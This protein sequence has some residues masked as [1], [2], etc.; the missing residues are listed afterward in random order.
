MGGR[1]PDNGMV[2]PLC[3]LLLPVNITVGCPRFASKHHHLVE[4]FSLNFIPIYYLLNFN[5]V[6]MMRMM[7][8]LMKYIFNYF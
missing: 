1:H 5:V 6:T 8:I 4:V 7:V 3:R 2:D